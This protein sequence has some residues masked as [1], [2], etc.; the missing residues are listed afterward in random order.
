MPDVEPPAGRG[1]LQHFISHIF[2]FH[3]LFFYPSAH[4]SHFI[5]HI[6]CIYMQFYLSTQRPHSIFFVSICAPSI[7]YSN[8]S[9]YSHPIFHIFVFISAPS[10]FYSSYFWYLCSHFSINTQ[11]SSA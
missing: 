9:T 5:S 1:W 4:R 2:S 6:F 8:I 11:A 3:V 7:F 10:T